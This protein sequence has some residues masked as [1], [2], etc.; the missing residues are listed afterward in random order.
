VVGPRTR[1]RS[2]RVASNKEI[3]SLIRPTDGI[4]V[5]SV[6]IL[7]DGFVGGVAKYNEDNGTSVKV[8]GW[9]KELEIG[10]F[11]GDFE[12]QAKG[13]NTTQNFIDQGADVIMPVG[14]GTL[15]AAK[16][17]DDVAV[18]W[19]DADGF[20][21]NS[22]YGDVILTSVIKEIGQSVFDTIE[23]A[24]KGSFTN[25]PYVGT[26]A[27]G[28]V[29]IAPFHNFDSKVSQELKDQV[30]DLEKQIIAGT[31]KVTSVNDHKKVTSVNDH[32]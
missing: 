19:V 16:E 5:P 28:G 2:A 12:D 30:A 23:E 31:L 7:L 10:S 9:D 18:I 20:L 26:L 17:A 13:K 25:T 1:S 29:S 4:Q 27:N 24:S 32:K 21:T 11:T 6:S 14:A 22:D 3:A 8:L 15:A